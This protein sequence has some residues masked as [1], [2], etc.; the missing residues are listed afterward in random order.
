MRYNRGGEGCVQLIF[1]G[2]FILIGAYGVTYGFNSLLKILGYEFASKSIGL[3]FGAVVFIG[4]LYIIFNIKNVL[5]QVL[6]VI[7]FIFNKN[8]IRKLE[9][10]YRKEVRI[11]EQRLKELLNQKP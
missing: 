2:S 10:D 7:D 3:T 5:N 11:Q 4:L 8:K 6:P 1:I 9:E